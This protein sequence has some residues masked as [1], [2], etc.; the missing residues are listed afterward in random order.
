M[1]IRSNVEFAIQLGLNNS[2]SDTMLE[3]EKAEVL[4]TMQRSTIVQMQLAASA[5]AQAVAM[6]GV[7][8]GRLLYVEADAEVTL[9]INGTEIVVL[10]RMVDPASTQA[11]DVCAYAL[12]TAEFTSLSLTNPSATAAVNVTIAIVGDIEV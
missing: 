12:L 7:A 5:T 6:G 1:G 3:R 9:L 2:L 10:K 4:D 8:T 11:D